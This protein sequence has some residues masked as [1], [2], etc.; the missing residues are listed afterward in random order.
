MKRLALAA[1]CALACSC[2]AVAA[3]KKQF[4]VAFSQAN[5]AE[6]YRA[7]Q[8]ALMQK[9]WRQQPD[10]KPRHRRRP[11]GQQQA[12]RADGDVHPP[13][14][15][16]ADRRPQRAGRAHRGD[17]PGDG[18]EDPG[19]L[20]GARHP[21]AELHQLRPQRQRRDRPQGGAVHRRPPDEEVRRA[22]GQRRRD[23]RA[24]RRGGRDQPGQ[25]R[26]GGLRQV[27]RASRSSPTRW[28]T[29]SRRRPRTG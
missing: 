1:L 5:N 9:L 29:G 18:G 12:G 16:P 25:G 10:V 15:R 13:K 22:E 24:A 23:A 17:G 20:P 3:A 2:A 21:S 26:E 7:A 27:P 6:P 4:V 28:P 19:H 8:N 14:A 11:A